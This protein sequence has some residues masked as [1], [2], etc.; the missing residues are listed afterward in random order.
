GASKLQHDPGK[1]PVANEQV[2]A[3]AEEFV[4]DA[5]PI[6]QAEEAGDRFVLVNAEEVGRTSDAQGR[7][8]GHGDTELKLDAKLSNHR[9]ELR[10]NE[11]HGV[12]AAPCQEEP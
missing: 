5:A 9:N 4:W 3:T 8:R 7:D 2:R 6:E 11:A 10:V 12:T 1:L